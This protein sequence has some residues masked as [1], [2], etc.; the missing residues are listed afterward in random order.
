MDIQAR[1]QFVSDNAIEKWE[2]IFPADVTLYTTEMTNMKKYGFNYAYESCVFRSVGSDTL[3]SDVL[4]R[5]DTYEQAKE[6]HARLTK[7]LGLNFVGE[8]FIPE[9]NKRFIL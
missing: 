6:G 9:L 7:E 4:E 2:W 8:F 3:E 1:K 5:Y